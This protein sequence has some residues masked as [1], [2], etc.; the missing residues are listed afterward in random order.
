M[1]HFEAPRRRVNLLAFGRGRVLLSNDLPIRHILL[2][3]RQA[4]QLSLYFI[5][6]IFAALCLGY[7]S[8]NEWGV[9]RHAIRVDALWF[10]AFV[11]AVWG[12]KSLFGKNAK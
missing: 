9:S 4:G 11:G 3:K 1:A 7:L 12:A 2:M 6:A 8:H 5:C 10:A